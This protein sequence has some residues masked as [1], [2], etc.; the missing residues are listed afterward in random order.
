M[1]CS[2]GVTTV[3]V[4]TEMQR[5]LRSSPQ[6]KDEFAEDVALEAAEEKMM[7]DDEE[8]ESCD[9]SGKP[10]VDTEKLER[11]MM[12][13]AL[14]KSVVETSGKD[15]DG[16]KK[17]PHSYSLRKRNS[18]HGRDSPD[19]EPSRGRTRSKPAKKTNPVKKRP[20]PAALAAPPVLPKRTASGNSSSTVKEENGPISEAIQSTAQVPN[21]L[22][23][24]VNS[25]QAYPTAP[26]PPIP[27]PFP[28]SESKEECRPDAAASAPSAI[29]KGNEFGAPLA[30]KRGRIFSIDI[31]RK[32]II[33][34]YFLLFC[35]RITHK[36]PRST[37]YHSRRVGISRHEH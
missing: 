14:V 28:E 24:V 17:Q 32:G 2:E 10:V 22:L 33:L 30:A 23:Q 16:D 19:E 29:G 31:D 13:V 20:V 8:I 1:T 4:N 35:R 25:Q 3:R 26:L 11:R 5:T 6:K 9:E 21:P 34:D 36:K 12:T 7:E 15:S 37:L 18:R 27:C